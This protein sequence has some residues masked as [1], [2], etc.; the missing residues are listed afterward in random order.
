MVVSGEIGIYKGLRS[1]A[2][3]RLAILHKGDIFGEMA[4]FD[5]TQRL[6]GAKAHTQAIC[7]AISQQE[8]ANRLNTVD[9]V[10]KSIMRCMMQRVR[11]VTAEAARLRKQVGKVTESE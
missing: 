7:L 5:D 10:I 9:P 8:F 11:A 3:L 2:P 1:E 6:A 4:L